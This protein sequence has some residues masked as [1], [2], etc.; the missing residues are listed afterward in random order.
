M[1]PDGWKESCCTHGQPHVVFPHPC[2][3]CCYEENFPL[4]KLLPASIGPL[5]VQVLPRALR[6]IK[7][8]PAAQ[9]VLTAVSERALT[10]REIIGVHV[11][12]DTKAALFWLYETGMLNSGLTRDLTQRTYGINTF[13]RILL[14]ALTRERTI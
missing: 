9:H 10:Q 4:D 14:E 12:T 6:R 7:R 8:W 2:D 3:S 1:R 5:A 11:H 13:G